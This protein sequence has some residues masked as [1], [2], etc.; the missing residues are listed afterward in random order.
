MSRIITFYSY[1]GGVGRTFSLCNIGVLLAQQ[2]KKVLLIDW[3]LEA[4]GLHRYFESLDVISSSLKEKGLIHL[5]NNVANSKSIDTDCSVGGSVAHWRHYVS[6]VK[7]NDSQSLD[8]MTSGD[9][10][11]DYVSTVSNF[12]WSDFFEN[13]QGGEILDR[14]R[15]EWKEEY[16]F[17]LIDSRTGI[18][19]SS[20]VCTVFL[21]DILVLVFSANKQSFEQGVQVAHGVQLS[22]KKLAVRRPPLAI[23]PLVGKFDGRD[24]IDESEKWLDQFGNK[25][26]PFYDDWLPKNLSPRQILEVTKI[27]YVTRF[28]FGEPLVV[29]SHSVSDPELPGYYL[30]HAAQLLIS[31]FADSYKIIPS[32]KKYLESLIEDFYNMLDSPRID[33]GEIHKKLE[34]IH[35]I[36]GSNELY[37]DLLQ[38][39]GNELYQRLEMDLAEG[40]L[41]RAFDLSREI[42][43]DVHTKTIDCLIDLS[44]LLQFSNRISEA[45]LL[46]KKYLSENENHQNLKISAIAKIYSKLADLY[47][48][49]DK[50][51]ESEIIYKKMLLKLSESS[52][53]NNQ[54]ILR[55]LNELASLYIKQ[56]RYEDALPLLKESVERTKDEY[57]KEH[58]A[59]ANALNRLA[60]LYKHQ[61]RFDESEKI[62]LQAIEISR[63]TVGESDL[64]FGGLIN[65]L[66]S[67][68]VSLGRLDDAEPL[69]HQAKQICHDNLGDA[70]P[71]YATCLNNLARLYIE[72][73]RFDEA[74]PLILQDRDICR[75]TLGEHHPD[76]ATSLNNLAS[77]YRY[78]KRYKE[79]EPLFQQALE[80]RRVIYGER[81]PKYGDSLNNLAAL[82]QVEGRLDEA[83]SLFLEAFE[84]RNTL[85]GEMHPSVS[86]SYGNLACL[87]ELQGRYEEAE[88]F[89]LKAVELRRIVLGEKHPDYAD[90]LINLARFYE[91]QSRYIEA[92]QY[93]LEGIKVMNSSLGS[94]HPKSQRI[95]NKYQL[96]NESHN[97]GY[98]N[99]K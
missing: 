52:G 67:L 18:T 50:Q 35:P 4:P 20:G 88:S 66:A 51:T 47:Q 92:D 27:P 82:Y 33:Q 90:S 93:Y 45:E 94:E 5:L 98:D 48:E 56:S 3:D 68:Y 39:L 84:I 26:K 17:I 13:H 70:H 8:I 53:N 29:L 83:E 91:N 89:F 63:A 60:T 22:R 36:I 12:S 40:Y 72:Q 9:K 65:N 69:Y 25:L 81:H 6:E 31:D 1:K 57:G 24:E 55:P 38:R 95:K 59:L 7:I 2:D 49:S 37:L 61:G 73:G 77:L 71:N 76:Y 42:N 85:L 14:W 10:S 46:Y 41:R 16:D 87:Y 80:I 74:E 79:A 58:L 78:Q 75:N 11:D 43:G 21:P 44:E 96:F 99:K 97:K 64:S 62:I 30:T 32:E 15:S 34:T 28:S 23:L 54:I 19:D 86:D